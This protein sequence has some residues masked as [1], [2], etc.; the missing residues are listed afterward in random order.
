MGKAL[1]EIGARRAWRYGLGQVQESLLRF[2]LL[3]PQLRVALLRLYGASVGSASIVH[4]VTFINLYRTGW[5]GLR[6]G[7]ECFVGDECLFDL[8]EPIS[9]GDQVTLAER[10]MILTH[11]NVGYRDHPLQERFPAHSAR[12]EIGSGSFV[13]AGAIILA[14]VR[15]GERSV[16]GAGAVV[17]REVPTD[18]VV[19]GVPARSLS[20]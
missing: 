4:P 2:S 3:P 13:G 8:A 6:A 19:A 5:R 17:D 15:I 9:L 7:R 20:G 12:V 16:V 14:G 11:M 10:V 1:G 18:G